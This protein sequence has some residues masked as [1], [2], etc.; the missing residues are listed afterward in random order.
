MDFKKMKN[1]TSEY[2]KLLE[3]LTK[4]QEVAEVITEITECSTDDHG[5][6]PDE[7]QLSEA[8]NDFLMQNGFC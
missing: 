8:V 1:G 3:I 4:A 7:I 5:L 6:E 2:S